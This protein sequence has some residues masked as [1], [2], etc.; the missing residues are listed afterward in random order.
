VLTAGVVLAALAPGAA[1][2]AVGDLTPQGCIEDA[3]MPTA[4]NCAVENKGL[5]GAFR[6]V[7][8]P[9]G[10]SVY[11]TGLSEDTVSIFKRDPATGALTPDGC[12]SDADV[13]LTSGCADFAEGLNEP[14]GIA[15]SPSGLDLYVAARADQAVVHLTRDPVTGELGDGGCVAYTGDSAGCGGA[16]QAGLDSP[17]DLVVDPDGASVYVADGFASGAVTRLVRNPTTGDIA[18]SGTCVGDPLGNPGCGSTTPGLV[19]AYRIAISPDGDSL[20]VASRGSGAVTGLTAPGLASIG[21]FADDS[22]APPGCTGVPGLEGAR[23]IAVSPD[24]NSIYANARVGAITQFARGFGGTFSRVGC[25]QDTGK[26]FGCAASTEGLDQGTDIVVSPDNASVYAV[27]GE[28]TLV[29]LNRAATGALTPSQCFAA[30]GV[31]NG[32]VGVKGLAFPTGLSASPDGK[33]L[34]VAANGDD[35]VARF[36]RGA[37]AVTPPPPPSNEVRVETEKAKCKGSCKKIKVKVVVDVPGT[38]TF[39]HAPPGVNAPCNIGG[40]GPTPPERALTKKSKAKY[41]KPKTVEAKQAGTVSTTLKLTKQARK[42][43]ARKGKLKFTLQVDFT[44]TGGTLT[45]ER[46]KLAVKGKRPKK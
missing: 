14:F 44:P 11:V 3:R 6:L 35:V 5:L 25:V 13:F 26:A 37:G 24:G 8:S 38:V 45:S 15:V 16:T 7:T 18:A 43:I 12:I 23:G 17:R 4:E 1:E 27:G 40:N 28:H 22:A 10:K 19:E 34:Y 36:D 31:N 29:N 21:C 9:D 30:S 46:S 33:S 39:C 41:V 32:C 42:K 2:G 20:Y